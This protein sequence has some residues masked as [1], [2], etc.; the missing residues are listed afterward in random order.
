MRE[1]QDRTHLQRALLARLESNRVLLLPSEEVL[2]KSEATTDSK[3][4][5]VRKRSGD[6]RGVR[7][8][9]AYARA[10]LHKEK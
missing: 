1:A 6:K 10:K 3:Q 2:R 4:L 8:D 9:L 5:A 7:L